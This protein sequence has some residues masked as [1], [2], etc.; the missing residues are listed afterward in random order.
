MILMEEKLNVLEEMVSKYCEENSIEYL[1][2]AVAEKGKYTKI[3]RNIT[4]AILMEA[5]Q[6]I[7]KLIQF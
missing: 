7:K 1:L 5:E 4:N 6:V 2:V 3:S